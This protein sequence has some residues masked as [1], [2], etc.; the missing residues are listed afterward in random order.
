MQLQSSP[1]ASRQR[2]SQCSTL[3]V[4]FRGWTTFLYGA[5]LPQARQTRNLGPGLKKP[6][7]LIGLTVYHCS[8]FPFHS[9][10]GGR[11]PQLGHW[12]QRACLPSNTAAPSPIGTLKPI[13][14]PPYVWLGSHIP[15]ISSL[16]PRP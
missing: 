5:S 3:P 4:P 16:L 2:R 10:S 7:S 6:A 14:R 15:Y 1:L 13:T 11:G 8:R 9:T 12:T